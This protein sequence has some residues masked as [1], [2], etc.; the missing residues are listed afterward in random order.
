MSERMTDAWAKKSFEQLKANLI[1][2]G[3][4][5]SYVLLVEMVGYLGKSLESE[6]AKVTELEN[7]NKYLCRDDESYEVTLIKR[8]EAAEARVEEL[9]SE[10]ER[11]RYELQTKSMQ[12]EMYRMEL[13]ELLP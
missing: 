8:A 9:K 13:S 7:Q 11:L 2:E 5:G 4:K 1:K 3:M 10:N 6:R 12:A